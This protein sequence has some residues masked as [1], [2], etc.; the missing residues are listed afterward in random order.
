MAV[1]WFPRSFVNV[2]IPQRH[3][4]VASGTIPRRTVIRSPGDTT[5]LTGAGVGCGGPGGVRVDQGGVEGHAAMSSNRSTA[6]DAA[7]RRFFA[8]TLK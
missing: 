7:L 3:Q 4:H 2:S 5:G 6:P 8:A 1:S